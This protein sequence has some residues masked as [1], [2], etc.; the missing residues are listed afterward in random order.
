[1]APR[2]E[3]YSVAAYRGSERFAFVSYSH[4]DSALA[5]PELEALATEGLRFYYDEGIHPGHTWDDEL[6]D[7]IERCAVFVFFVTQHSP[8]SPNCRRE[9]AFA[10]DHGKPLIAVHLQDVELPPGLRLSIGNRQ[11]I[12][13]S[14]FD[15]KGYRERLVAAL[16]EHIGAAAPNE[17]GV[18]APAPPATGAD[19]AAPKRRTRLPM[20]ALAVLSI[21]VIGVVF[22]LW[23]H[24]ETTRVARADQFAKIEQLIAQDQYGAAFTLAHPLMADASARAD[25]RLQ[26]LWKQIVLPG[27]PLVAEAGATL[28][29]KAYDD[30]NDGWIAAGQTP[31]KKMFDLPKDVLRI[32]VEKAGF[33]TGDFVVA[34]PGPSIKS[35]KSLENDF[36]KE[37]FAIP[38]LPLP[39]APEGKLAD[40]MVLVPATD[41]PIFLTQLADDTTGYD[42]R[43]LPEFA[44]SRFEVT[45]REYQ[46]FVDA[47]GY[48]NPTYW[49]GL[50]FRDE[51]RT[52]DWAEARARFVDRTGRPGPADWE[53]S[54]YPAKQAEFPVVG[55]SWY[56][57]V[58]YARFRHLAVPTIHHWARA[59]F[60][61][62]EGQFE[63]APA[64]AAASR[65]LADGPVEARRQLGPGPW[66]T[67]NTAGNVRE[68][69]WNFVG[70]HAVA[71]GGSWSDY[72]AEYNDLE[73]VQP[74]ERSDRIGLRLMDSFGPV[75][76]E[77]LKPI[78]QSL[79]EASAKREPMSD[80][81]FE[82]MRFQFTVGAHTP[83]N[84]QV[85][86]FA[87]SDMWTAEE[88]LLTYAGGDVLSVYIVLPR[89]SRGAL[90][91]V[92]F[93][94]PGG[95]LPRP[96]RE[97]LEQ[98]RT[99]DVIVSGGRAL[100]MPI[101]ADQY[102]RAQPQTTDLEVFADRYRRRA[103][104]FYQDGVRTIDYLS[105]RSDM[106][107]RRVGFMGVSNGSIAIAPPL[108]TMEGRIR[109]A[110]LASA[111]V[112]VW[113]FPIRAPTMD[114]VNYAPRIHVPVLMING[115][116]DSVLPLELSQVRLFDLLGT[117]AAD[118]RHVL[119]DVSHFTFPH[120]Q[121]AKEVNDWFDKYLGP[122]K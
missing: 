83:T 80:E 32:R 85:T 7:A 4:E 56:E 19:R 79:D 70:D 111:G 63:T 59:A 110:V 68:W 53:L 12:V 115:R 11:A 81:A 20:A 38:D 39:L 2:G 55:I 37:G 76:E 117:P 90:Q 119:F 15:E 3:K 64:I 26:A 46:A 44:I 57:A 95:G 100:V 5:F 41:E 67:W 120:S 52:L 122:V 34:N 24:T 75:P 40:D 28:S 91:P 104:Q 65:F 9:I 114:I 54:K 105:S 36:L 66:G 86:Q 47:G 118:K 71:L 13:R 50:Q 43:K 6:A 30:T 107:A 25:P 31:I 97:V 112:W 42:R 101:W 35:V 89:G 18:P 106:D 72:N 10:I 78:T 96:N 21:V 27:T 84:V 88:V 51:G 99:A 29:Y 49:E 116:Y 103:V 14:R 102:Q 22:A 60:G 23:R 94:F 121:L 62:W 93:G 61:P 113:P 108:L 1:M 82:A 17:T 58:A 74:M 69:V 45:N 16:R 73:T 92:L 77:L 109:A 8:T 48:D 33:Q 98:L 87:E